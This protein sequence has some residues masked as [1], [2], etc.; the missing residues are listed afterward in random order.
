MAKIMVTFTATANEKEFS[1]EFPLDVSASQLVTGGME[2]LEGEAELW[3]MNEQHLY[4]EFYGDAE[5]ADYNA[6]LE[7]IHVSV[8]DIDD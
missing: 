6:T 8:E 1:I 7:D 4:N 5:D 2:W 3:I